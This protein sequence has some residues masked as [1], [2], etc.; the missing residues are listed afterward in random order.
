MLT[1]TCQKP[2]LNQ[3]NVL[4]SDAKVQKKNI[5]R[6]RVRQ[7]PNKFLLY[8]FSWIVSKRLIKLTAEKN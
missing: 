8:S 3:N 7:L 2:T 6:F 4:I 1:S 5:L